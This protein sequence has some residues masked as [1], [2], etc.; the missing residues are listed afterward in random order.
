M[1]KT[2]LSNPGCPH[3]NY[4]HSQKAGFKNGKRRFKCISYRCNK[5]FMGDV[6][7]P[8][9]PYK[10]IPAGPVTIPQYRW[11]GTRLS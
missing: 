7:P 6:V 5:Y 9:V 4:P 3:C 2:N 11:G 10:G 1:K 8:K